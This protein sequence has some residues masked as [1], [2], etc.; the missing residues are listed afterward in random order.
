M[1]A[2]FRRGVEGWEKDGACLEHFPIIWH[3]FRLRVPP[4]GT[5]LQAGLVGHL[6]A[7]EA[8]AAKI[9]P[10]LHKAVE[11]ILHVVHVQVVSIG[12]SRIC[13]EN[14]RQVGAAVSDQTIAQAR[15]R[16]GGNVKG[17]TRCLGQLHQWTY[18]P[19]VGDH[20]H[21]VQPVVGG[22]VP[23]GQ[24]NTLRYRTAWTGGATTR[25]AEKLVVTPILISL[26]CVSKLSH[27]QT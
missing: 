24:K 17:C 8:K 20:A 21:V 6:A 12:L 27:L 23:G 13:A 19:D 15:R 18:R 4:E 2:S 14:G 11:E 7:N 10:A 26:C 3:N 9:T 25:K 22:V 1:S 5:I 16:V